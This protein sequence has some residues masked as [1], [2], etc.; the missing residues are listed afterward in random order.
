MDG[1]D[2]KALAGAKF[3][4][5][6]DALG[7]VKEITKTVFV[8]DA[9]G[10]FF[11]LKDGNYTTKEP[12]EDSTQIVGETTVTIHGTKDLYVV[13]G[14]S[15]TNKKTVGSADYLVFKKTTLTEYTTANAGA[16]KY[17][18][19]T[20]SNGIITFTGLDAGFYTLT[21]TE[22]P[23]GYNALQGPIYIDVVYTA[24]DPND[25]NTAC[26]WTVT[27]YEDEA[28]TKKIATL[29]SEDNTAQLFLE[30]IENKAGTELPS[31]GGIGTTIFYVMGSILVICA[32]VVLVT[33]RRMAA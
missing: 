26:T 15:D 27:A 24:P 3:T 22:A 11:L 25:G 16:K 29:S 32:G 23:K 21:E 7:K 33:R 5:E 19:T 9:A 6:G 20:D 30:K 13:A 1:E 12:T 18:V 31:T 17:E 28:K 14:A 8:P 10:T 4:L 2:E